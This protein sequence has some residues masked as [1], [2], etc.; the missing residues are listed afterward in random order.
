VQY[1]IVLAQ[2]VGDLAAR[3]Q[4]I[5]ADE[6]INHLKFDADLITLE[7][8]SD[9]QAAAE[10]LGRLIDA[11]LPVAEFHQVGLDLEQAYLRV[12]VPQVE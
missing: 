9:R 7:Y 11:G 5:Q 6:A 12:G 8:N 4:G 3:L 1:R 2:R 10:L